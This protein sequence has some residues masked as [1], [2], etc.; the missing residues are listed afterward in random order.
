MPEKDRNKELIKEDVNMADCVVNKENAFV[1][2]YSA[3]SNKEIERIRSKYLPK[4]ESKLDKLIRL[5][6]QTEKKGQ[7]VSIAL[8]VLGSL[9]LGVGMCC[10]M[11]WNVGM[12]MMII[13]IVIGMLG[14]GM[15]GM[16]YPIYK[17]LTAI[18]RTKIAE[19]II[20][21]SNELL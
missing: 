8:G 13:G 17:K 18:E 12:F 6:K 10:A 2:S 11:V 20:A 7:A 4:E 21:L 16:A 19:Q 9:F 5:D 15:L 1:Y 14:I 3:Q